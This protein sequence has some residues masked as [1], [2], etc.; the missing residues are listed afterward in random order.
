[1]V[2]KVADHLSPYRQDKIYDRT[3]L[4]IARSSLAQRVEQ[5]GGRLQPPVVALR[6]VVLSQ[7]DSRQ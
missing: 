6:E 3:G 7:S 2:P 4:A 1:M 5:T